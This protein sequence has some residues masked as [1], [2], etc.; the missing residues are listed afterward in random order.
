MRMGKAVTLLIGAVF[1]LAQ[2]FVPFGSYAKGDFEPIVDTQ[3]RAVA[4]N[5]GLFGGQSLDIEVDPT[6]DNVYIT[7]MAPNGFFISN[8]KGESFH[9]LPSGANFGVGKEVEINPA[10]GDV[11]VLIGDSLLKSTD[12]GTNFT[13]IT[14]NLGANSPLGQELFYGHSRLLVGK[15]P[16]PNSNTNLA[17]SADNGATFSSFAVGINA[18]IQAMAASSITDTFYAAT[19]DGNSE[20]L[21]KS[22]DAGATWTEVSIPA[23][24][25]ISALGI[26]PT[27]VS[28]QDRIV[29]SNTRGD[30]S[31][32]VQSVNNGA[33]WT[34]LTDAE[35]RRIAMNYI[36]FDGER[37]Y[38]GHHYSTD[39][40][41]T[42]SS[43]NNHT[44]L[45]NVY[46]DVFA[47]DPN[48]INILF[49]NTVYSLA[50]S[51]DRGVTWADKATGITSVKV[52]DITQ[53]NKK[54]V[55]YLAANGGLAKTTNFTSASPDWQ[56]PLLGTG[57]A[58]AFAVWVKP[59]N[60]NIVLYGD[61][62]QIKKSIDGGTNWETVTTMGTGNPGP[63]NIVEIASV[64]GDDNTIYAALA[65]D[66]LARMDTGYVF[67]STDGG[68]TWTDLDITSDASVSSLTVA[69]NGNVYAGS[70]SRDAGAPN[71]IYKYSDGKWTKLSS[72]MVTSIL[73]D[74]EDK[75]VVYATI[76][77]M[78]SKNNGKPE[79]GLYKSTNAGEDWTKTTKGLENVNNLD[80]LTVQT[81]TSP[82]TLYLSGQGKN[83]NGAIY[84]SSNAGTTWGLFYTGLKQESFYAML[85]DGLAAGNDRGLY[86]IKSK[87]KVGVAASAKTVKKGKKVTFTITLKDAATKKKLT[88]R[89]VALYKKVGKKWKLVKIA[90][91]DKKAVATISVKMK[92]K[93]TFQVR[94]KPKKKSDKAEYTLSKSKKITIK[95]KKQLFG[96]CHYCGDSHLV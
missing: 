3:K 38:I 57:S 71:G 25:R 84:K 72:K 45:S 31:N 76:S 26:D 29:L 68:L 91:T 12:K 2:V 20:K 81:S 89:Q 69:K 70:S 74:P 7:T 18:S 82:N 21:Y 13:D 37:M 95:V 88:K 19:S 65:N 10:N 67:K 46:A 60:A 28:G 41:A 42:W 61:H 83:L 9:G 30:T 96:D 64:P 59:D 94:F 4:T 14:Q 78:M 33:T 11:Y 15:N 48:N 35:G 93:T 50:K 5:L 8:D 47:F 85:F 53:A 54:A 52:Y 40:G 66:D 56:Y 34:E 63:G 43:M 39:D 86:D 1:V 62:N 55:V 75:D 51:T 6:S 44:P 73:A 58:S 36:A 27:Q 17:I 87:A 23:G 90:K 16:G 79:G 22:T 80:T 24:Q 77:G 49:T 32:S 92:K